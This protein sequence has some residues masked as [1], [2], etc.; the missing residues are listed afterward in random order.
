[1]DRIRSLWESKERR[2]K[3]TFAFIFGAIFAVIL[4][5]CFYGVYPLNPN[6]PQSIDPTAEHELME[7]WLHR[8][9]GPE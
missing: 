4:R 5:Y 6:N 1:M 7:S 8:C 2:N 3:F 9:P